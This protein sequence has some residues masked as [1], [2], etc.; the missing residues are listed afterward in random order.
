MKRILIILFFFS[1]LFFLFSCQKETK[2][3]DITTT[4]FFQYD[5]VN[6]IVDNKMSVSLVTP[7]EIDI[8]NY[9]PT[10][11]TIKNINNSKLFL[12]TSNLIEPWAQ[13]INLTTGNKFNIST[14]LD[15]NLNNGH[16]DSHY[17]TS[18]ETFVTIINLILSEIIKIDPDNKTYYETNATNYKN[19]IIQVSDDFLG[20]LATKN[21]KTIFYV[22]HNSMSAFATFFGINIIPI[23]DDIRPD[24][25]ITAKEIVK[26][27][28]AI[29]NLRPSH[30]FIPE[31]TT[32]KFTKTIQNELK[33]E[34][35]NLKILELHGYH[36][37]TANDYKSHISYLDLLT[38]NINNLKESWDNND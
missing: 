25:D 17:W 8:H 36:N 13:K 9:E 30:L 15:N 18:P 38:R 11:K 32:D 34:N 2:Q 14:H 27:V 37:L 20:Y 1:L 10:P 6:Q 4:M 35:L 3:F 33:S 12:Y 5:V 7:L 16:E 21:L 23:V 26:I 24:H 29:K 22:G 31:L 19:E 28:E